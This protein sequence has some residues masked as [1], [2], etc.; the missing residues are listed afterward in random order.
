MGGSSPS[1]WMKGREPDGPH[2]LRRAPER[3]GYPF[4]ASVL[5]GGRLV[6]GRTTLDLSVPV[7]RRG[8]RRAEPFVSDRRA[9]LVR[10]AIV[11]GKGAVRSFSGK[12]SSLN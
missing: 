3:V 8:L 7:S 1:Y 10:S 6:L 12:N 11:V 2:P 5:M 9:G 4:S